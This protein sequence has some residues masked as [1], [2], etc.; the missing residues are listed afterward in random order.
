MLQKRLIAVG[1]LIFCILTG[2]F[3][4]STQVDPESRFPFRLGLDLSGGT[5]LIYQADVSKVA[6]EDVD[7]AMG[8]LRDTIERRVNIFGV[9]EPLV[10]V[11]LTGAFGEDSH[12]LI[13]ELPGVTDIDEAVRLIGE[14]PLLEFK[15]EKSQSEIEAILAEIGTSTTPTP[16]QVQSFYTDTGL[17]GRYLERAQI[18]FD[19]FSG[20]PQVAI[21]FDGEGADLF[22]QI[23]RDHVGESLAIF[24]DG[25]II[26]APAINYVITGGNAVI[27]GNFNPQEAQILARDLNYGALPV[28]ITLLSTQSVGS[29]LGA[30]AVAN[31]IRAGGI[32]FSLVVLFMLLW[33][34]LPGFVAVVSLCGYVLIMLALFK[35]IPVTLT[36]AGIAGLILS[37]GMA[38][39][40]N[41]LIFERIKEEIRSGKKAEDAIP[42][43]FARAW[44]SIRDSNISSII[45][46]VVL[47]WL[48]TSLVKGFALTFGIGVII[49][50]FSAIV[51]SRAF[52]LALG[53]TGSGKWARILL[54]SGFS[55]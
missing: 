6:E 41:I 46:A 17:T 9:S 43:G 8:A 52:L 20:E 33:Y 14:T 53:I 18:A 42:E 37:V 51:F 28:P 24:L 2:Y 25:E 15:I 50:M 48:G 22:E 45:T 38:V 4:Y 29:A 44:M 27:T 21:Q 39:D 12:R 32:G 5:Q 7:G 31:G 10:Q 36:A 47:F 16:E 26:S 1:L 11:E 40:A 49:S 19:S 55:R 34:R 30:E 23:T 54:G 13:V 3:V 35:L